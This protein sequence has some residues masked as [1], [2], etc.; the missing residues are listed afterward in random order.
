[1]TSASQPSRFAPISPRCLSSSSPRTAGHQII[2]RGFHRCSDKGDEHRGAPAWRRRVPPQPQQRTSDVYARHP[3][4]SGSSLRWMTRINPAMAPSP[5]RSSLS[6]N[7]I[8]S[9]A[10]PGPRDSRRRYSNINYEPPPSPNKRPGQHRG[11]EF[12]LLE[13]SGILTR[14]VII[15]AVIDLCGAISFKRKVLILLHFLLLLINPLMPA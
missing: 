12:S 6:S 4:L 10:R 8:L 13:F 5:S 7:N 3:L 9:R 1:M 11:T 2:S 15:R 14:G